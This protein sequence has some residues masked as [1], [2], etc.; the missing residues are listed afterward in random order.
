VRD[1]GWEGTIRSPQ[2]WR[3]V[4]FHLAY[5]NQ[6][7]KG[8]GSIT[9]GLINFTP[10]E[11]GFF[12]NDHDQR[13]TLTTG[14]EATLPWRAWMATNIN[15]G[16]GFLDLN[17]PQHTAADLSMGKSWRESWKFTVTV[18]NVANSRYLL[19]RDSAFAGTHYNDPRQFIAQV[20]YRFYY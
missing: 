5:S 16:S 17:G 14:G 11:Q 9:G 1:S 3:R 6:V 18:L 8:A 15:Y 10:P 2:V 13:D 12:Y 4:R 20:R 7:V 19:G